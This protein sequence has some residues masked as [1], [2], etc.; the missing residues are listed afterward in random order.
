MRKTLLGI[1]AG[2][3][4]F[5]CGTY[6]ALGGA[7]LISVDSVAQNEA[8]LAAKES[9]EE[10]DEKPPKGKDKGEKKAKNLRKRKT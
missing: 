6:L 1:I 8:S 4:L 5:L 3:F 10:K 9:K 2:V 7:S